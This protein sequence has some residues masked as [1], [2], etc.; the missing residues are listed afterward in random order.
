[1][2]YGKLRGRGGQKK[3]KKRKLI[4][5]MIVLQALVASAGKWTS[6]PD[7]YSRQ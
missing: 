4:V 1:M 7:L 5:R 3:M 6:A 2:Q